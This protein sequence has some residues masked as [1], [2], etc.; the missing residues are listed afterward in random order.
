MTLLPLDFNL[1]SDLMYFY[2]SSNLTASVPPG[3]LIAF[4]IFLIDSEVA[5]PRC[6]SVSMKPVVKLQKF[7]I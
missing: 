4:A 7:Y 3:P 2:P 1:V 6:K 5:L